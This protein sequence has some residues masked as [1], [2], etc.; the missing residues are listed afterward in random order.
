MGSPT[1]LIPPSAVIPANTQ[2][3]WWR[4]RIWGRKDPGTAI[5]DQHFYRQVG[6]L[7]RNKQG[8]GRPASTTSEARH[9]QALSS[10]C[11]AALTRHGRSSP[12]R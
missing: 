1:H 3:H 6:G 7:G 9:R 2:L 10:F 5:D 8:P 11:E 12:I 4:H